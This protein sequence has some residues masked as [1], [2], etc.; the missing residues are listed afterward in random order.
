M[1]VLVFADHFLWFFYFSDHYHP[2]TEVSTFFGICIW[3]VPFLFF[4]SLTANDFTLPSYDPNASS[5]I[6]PSSRPMPKS[7]N[8]VK[9]F[10]GF[11]IQ[12]KEELL[13]SSS[14]KDRKSF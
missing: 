5:P 8:L 10:L 2:F 3:I 9:R 11:L 7:T 1:A 14:P 6:S 12:K 13:P 4:I